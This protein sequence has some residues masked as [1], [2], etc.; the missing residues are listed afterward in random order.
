MQRNA[1]LPVLA[2][3][4]LDIYN[5]DRR[6]TS[7]AVAGIAATTPAG[8]SLA[9]RIADRISDEVPTL[10]AKISRDQIANLMNDSLV[11]AC[12]RE[13]LPP[14]TPRARAVLVDIAKIKGEGADANL[15]KFLD[16]LAALIWRAGDSKVILAEVAALLSAA[17]A[18]GAR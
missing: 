17:H 7:A 2:S 5:A 16:C 8:R 18:E 1:N 13:G 11:E 12:R 14:L 3:T 15:V 6:T 4:D 9:E 10:A